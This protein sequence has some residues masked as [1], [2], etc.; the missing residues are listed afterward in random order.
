MQRAAYIRPKV[1]ICALESGSLYK[2]KPKRNM[3]LGA[4][5]CRKPTVERFSRLVPSVNKRSGKAVRNAAPIR[6]RSILVLIRNRAPV[7]LQFK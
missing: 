1:N 7:P 5:Y 2:K 3:Q 6:K 4:I